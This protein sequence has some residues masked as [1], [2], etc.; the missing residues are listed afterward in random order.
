M[1]KI[2]HQYIL[3]LV[4]WL[5]LISA[6][7]VLPPP[8][9]PGLAGA[10]ALDAGDENDAGR[11]LDAGSTVATAPLPSSADAGPA[12]P[13]PPVTTADLEQA[14]LQKRVDDIEVMVEALRRS[15]ESKHGSA[16]VE[17][18]FRRVRSEAEVP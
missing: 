4:A 7:C 8:E 10:A 6:S 16:L 2:S 15:V 5:A 9:P 12:A 17:K 14:K 13:L 1:M 18:N 11:V 3:S